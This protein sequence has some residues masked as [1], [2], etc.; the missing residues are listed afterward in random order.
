MRWK[1]LERIKEKALERLLEINAAVH[2]GR[3]DNTNT[4]GALEAAKAMH[5]AACRELA[6]MVDVEGV[7][8]DD[9]LVKAVECINDA[10]FERPALKEELEGIAARLMI[11]YREGGAM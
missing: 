1:Q 5:E 9:P 8:D 3:A 7:P 11:A 10:I 6:L 2:E 4:R